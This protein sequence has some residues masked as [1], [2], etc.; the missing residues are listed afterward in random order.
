M[1]VKV[2]NVSDKLKDLHKRFLENERYQAEQYFEKKITPFEFL[3]I[4]TQDKNF[5]WLQPFSA[6]IAE[7]DAFTDEAETISQADLICIRDQIEFILQSSNTDLVNRYQ[8]HLNNDADFI[9]L[10]ASLKKV[11]NEFISET[12]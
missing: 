2:K 4:L 10:H 1:K 8:Y 11:M 5:A 3:L 9:M 12:R 6:M 7:I